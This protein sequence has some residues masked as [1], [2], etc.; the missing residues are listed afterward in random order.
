MPA[1]GRGANLKPSQVKAAPKPAPPKAGPNPFKGFPAPPQRSIE[2]AAAKQVPLPKAQ[3]RNQAINERNAQKKTISEMSRAAAIGQLNPNLLKT[4]VEN[5]SPRGATA[6]ERQKEAEERKTHIRQERADRAK[7]VQERIFGIPVGSKKSPLEEAGK[8]Q[9]LKEVGTN[10]GIVV[11]PGIPGLSKAV[12]LMGT[13]KAVSNLSSAIPGEVGKVA[14]KVGR[15]AVNI[16]TQA[17]PAAY[18][19]IKAGVSAAKGNPQELETLG[20][21]F[22]KESAVAHAFKGE[23]NKALGAAGEH[24]LG[25]ALEVGGVAGAADRVAGAIED[26]MRA[27]GRGDLHGA[28]RGATSRPP[29]EMPAGM[30]PEH[31][32]TVPQKPYSKGSVRRR[33][34]KAA[35]RRPSKIAAKELRHNFDR[36]ESSELAVTRNDRGRIQH[37]HGKLFGDH[38]IT[39]GPQR[40]ASNLIGS[41]GHGLI[42]DPTMKAKDGSYLW[43]Q[44]LEEAIHHFETVRDPRGEFDPKHRLAVVSHLK[45]LRKLSQDQAEHA[46]K[47]TGELADKAR[48]EE[49]ELRRQRIYTGDAMRNAKLIKAFQFHFRDQNPF[50]DTNNELG[51]SPFSL[52]G[53][54]V[55]TAEVV[56]KLRAKGVKEDHLVFA[57]TKPFQTEESAFVSGRQKGGRAQHAGHLTGVNFMRGH[58]DPAP[59]AF[60]RQALTTRKVINAARA[61]AEFSRRYVMKNTDLAKLIHARAETTKDLT[62]EQRDEF[63]KWADE[64]QAQKDHYFNHGMG[65]SGWQQAQQA[66]ERLKV[67]GIDL[68]PTRVAHQYASTAYRQGLGGRLSDMADMQDRMEPVNPS[69]DMHRTRLPEEEVAQN[70]RTAGPVGL[71]HPVIAKKISQYEKNLGES[72]LGQLPSS[73]WRQANVAYSIRHV[74][75]VMQELGIRALSGNYGVLSGMRMTRGGQF[76]REYAEKSNDPAVKHAYQ[77]MEAET[78]GTVASYAQSQ[79]IHTPL[80]RYEGTRLESPMRA[81]MKGE[82]KPFT[83]APLRGARVVVGATNKLTKGI[84]SAE[85]K[86]IEHPFTT[87]AYGKHIASEYKRQTGKRMKLVGAVNAAEQAFL[88]GQLD[89]KAL[90]MAAKQLTDYIGDWKNSSPGFRKAQTYSPFFR[91][92]VNSLKFVYWTMPKDHPMQSGL[93]SALETATRAQRLAEGQEY[94]APGLSSIP[95]GLPAY[96]QG[97]IP[98]FLK[99]VLPGDRIGAEYYSPPGAVSGGLEGGIGAVLPYATGIF[100]TMQGVNPLTHEK[101]EE[102]NPAT[103]KKEEIHNDAKLAWLGILAGLESF[104]PQYRY[105][106]QIAEGK[107]PGYV[108]R[109]LR[110]EKE[111][112]VGPKQGGSLGSGKLGSG[113]LGGGSLGSGKP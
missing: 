98:N 69:A 21:Q 29:K 48:A 62:S 15:E 23:W 33:V 88:K 18:Y 12:A 38:V 53:R 56:A 109:P 2:K 16:P 82:K 58:W 87:A 90:D 78:G 41:H 63:H 35:D 105:G 32:V 61:D 110:T 103:G 101:L 11:P 26:T 97:S 22:V 25:T 91:W 73:I 54:P 50:V 59:D 9:V 80:R 57:S 112:H 6:A 107:T 37:E 31:G 1:Q 75:G 46:Y 111:G 102:V 113:K 24:P 8:K 84:L 20:H 96:Q 30:V 93:I 51:S 89:P 108:F 100:N 70:D 44:Q 3:A 52:N 67:L 95:G 68:R 81:W 14:G 104:A 40:E 83:G 79:S 45:D 42:G 71:V 36:L 10:I 65:G 64:L 77:L 76:L 7:T 47:V 39:H 13:G 85:R 28:V 19:G 49:P 72:H 86:Y 60:T 5:Q 94:R 55:S 43:R 74:P 106:A 4:R 34:Q 27:V 92:Y 17:I 99:G 66:A